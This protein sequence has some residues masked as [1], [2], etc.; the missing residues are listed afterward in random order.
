MSSFLSRVL[1]FH[2]SFTAILSAFRLL[3]PC[4]MS[5]WC[6][7]SFFFRAAFPHSSLVASIFNFILSQVEH[8]S[9]CGSP[10]ERLKCPLKTLLYVSKETSGFTLGSFMPMFCWQTLRPCWL[11]SQECGSCFFRY[12]MYILLTQRP[13]LRNRHLGFF[14]LE[15]WDA[16]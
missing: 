11:H 13:G 2:V 12:S 1:P 9:E 10:N 15:L 8:M 5:L 3:Y 14:F 4:S 6:S 7:F 16:I